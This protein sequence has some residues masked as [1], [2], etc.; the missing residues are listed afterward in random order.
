MTQ[1]SSQRR[2]I[3][4]SCGNSHGR[5][6]PAV[7]PEVGVERPFRDREHDRAEALLVERQLEQVPSRPT[8]GSSSVWVGTSRVE[9]SRTLFSSK[10][11]RQALGRHL[12]AVADDPREL[13]PQVCPLREGADGLDRLG[14]PHGARL[15]SSSGSVNGTP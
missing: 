10:R 1:S 13:D 6:P 2:V 3:V 15:R 5:S 14:R 9:S 12:V 11:R 7:V 4:V 8:I